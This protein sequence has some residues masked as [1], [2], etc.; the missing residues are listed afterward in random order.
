MV[1]YSNFIIRHS[2]LVI[3]HLA[4]GLFVVFAFSSCKPKEDIVFRNV[5]D[6]TVDVTT[7]PMLKAKAVLYNPNN[8]KIKLRKI[9]IDVYVDGKKTGIVDQ[10]PKMVIPATA[11]FT[12]P[13]EVK[14]NMKELGLLDTIFSVIGG[15][16]MKVRYKGSISV[17][18]K[19]LPIRIPVDYESEV[20]I[21]L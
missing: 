16:K 17:T 4:L 6:I 14:L 12:V 18:Y 9:V 19:G 8:V 13:L 5:R 20:R 15:K 10:K 2:S 1:Q 11:E 3:R 21:R 7:E